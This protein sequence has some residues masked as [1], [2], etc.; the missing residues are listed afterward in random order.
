[1]TKT[2][3]WKV[4]SPVVPKLL[5]WQ[6]KDTCLC[7]WRFSCQ[8]T[9]SSPQIGVAVMWWQMPPKLSD[10]WQERFLSRLQSKFSVEQHLC[11]QFKVFLTEKGELHEAGV[12]LN[13]PRGSPPPPT[14]VWVHKSLNKVG[15][16]DKP[17]FSW[18]GTKYD[19]TYLPHFRQKSD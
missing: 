18:K 11:G 14:G 16:E 19:R 15:S 7:D 5:L 1:M 10:V 6:S 2:D 13:L 12:G 8:Q 9:Q 4:K 3:V 17:N